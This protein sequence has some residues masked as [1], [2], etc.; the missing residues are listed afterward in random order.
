MIS[1]LQLEDTAT[2]VLVNRGWI[3]ADAGR[4]S[5]PEVALAPGLQTLQGTVYVPPGEAYTLGQISDNEDWPRL[6]QA[7]DVPALSVMLNASLFPYSVRLD[8]TSTA[9][10]TIDWPLVNVSPEKHTGY[11]VQWFT[12]AAVLFILYILHSSNLWQVVT[13]GTRK[14][15]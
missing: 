14:Q 3:E 8:A 2:V 7:L 11:A 5:L 10:F 12:M 15:Q 4:R 6:V 1:Q 9:G 13:A